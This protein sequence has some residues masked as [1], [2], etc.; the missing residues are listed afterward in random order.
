MSEKIKHKKRV[1]VM[2]R[3][4][5]NLLGMARSLAGGDYDIEI[6]RLIQ[7]NHK[8]MKLV[9]KTYP[10]RACK[11][12]SA[13][14][15]CICNWDA[16]NLIKFLMEIYDPNRETLII[17]CD[18][19]AIPWLDENYEMLKEYYLFSDVN[20]T[21]GKVAEMMNK[22]N[23]K[24]MVLDFGLPAAKSHGIS[25]RDGNYEFP[26]GIDYPCFLK[27]ATLIMGGKDYLKRYDDE[28]S[29]KEAL[30]KVASKF[31]NADFLVEDFVDIKR[32][33]AI[34]GVSAGGKVLLPDGCLQ[35]V[36]GGHAS[37]KGIMAV[38]EVVSSPEILEFLNKLKA[39]VESINY[40]GMFDVDAIA[41][42]EKILFCE[43]NMRFGGSGYAITRCGVNFP[44]MFADYMFFNKELPSECKLDGIG[45]RFVSEKILLEDVTEKY[46][47]RE[48]AD[49]IIEKADI[50]FLM[51]EEDPGPFKKVDRSF[52]YTA[53]FTMALKELYKKFR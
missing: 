43:I 6:V 26:Q 5:N 46:M 41:D 31:K 10:E 27:P 38:G 36:E 35:F 33:Y 40:T 25:I 4:Y 16:D 30:K 2:S 45:K 24:R 1:L 11:Y 39:F 17:P 47:S 48:E 34:L 12:A 15:V 51:D 22:Q 19:L 52:R 32:E 29:L 23:Q 53:R 18:D 28:K 21:Q 7:I 9:A 13:Y 14:H 20:K 8:I 49:E 3:N 37:R 42:D 50:H 44:R